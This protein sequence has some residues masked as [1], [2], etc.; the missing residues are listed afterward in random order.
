MYENNT[1][2]IRVL[3]NMKGYIERK[4]S[5]IENKKYRNIHTYTILQKEM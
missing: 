1:L 4:D 3:I 2:F 5:K